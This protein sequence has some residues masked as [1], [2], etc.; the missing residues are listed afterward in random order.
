M[1]PR[2]HASTKLGLCLVGVLWL[3]PAM[4]EEAPALTTSERITRY[5]ELEMIWERAGRRCNVGA[6]ALRQ[7]R[8]AYGEAL[9]RAPLPE[10]SDPDLLLLQQRIEAAA[11]ALV[12]MALSCHDHPAVAE[13]LNALGAYP[14]V[15]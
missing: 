8:L 3:S 15:P 10:D 11:D 4:A 13:E 5:A 14:E 6:E 1:A 12:E 9:W 7:W 2:T